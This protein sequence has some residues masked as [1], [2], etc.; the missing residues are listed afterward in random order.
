MTAAAS[1]LTALQGD[2]SCFE[3][4]SFTTTFAS[5]T[6]PVYVAHARALKKRRQHIESQ[7][8]RCGAPDV[9]FVLCGDANV[10]RGLNPRLYR[11]LHPSY[12]RTDWS[13]P[14]VSHLPNGTL[15]LALKH[16]LAHAD[17]LR[18]G[19]PAALILEDDAV[20]PAGFWVALT[21]ALRPIPSDASLYFVGSYSRSTNPKLTLS[22]SP[23]VH[24]DAV[25]DPSTAVSLH[26]RLNGTDAPKPHILGTV[27]YVLFARGAR[28]LGV[29]PIR[30]EADVDLS[31][32][33]PTS[34]CGATS[35]HCAVAAPPA[36]YGPSRWL[37]WQDESL[38]KDTTHGQKNSVRDGWLRACRQTSSPKA[39]SSLLKACKRFGF[40]PPSG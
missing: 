19:L 34:R 40:A 26:R 32:L 14:G 17:A 1:C 15:S 35:P 8:Q 6:L 24:R 23:L 33:T 7:L 18:R 4:V 39:S 31:L 38:A 27:A 22:N 28:H 30:A 29:Q 20:L 36:Q 3:R 16:R 25:D 37:A 21:Q 2:G 13:R 5:H 11:C 9:T 10:V 12:T